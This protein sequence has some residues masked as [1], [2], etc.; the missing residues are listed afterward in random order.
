MQNRDTAILNRTKTLLQRGWTQNL[1]ARQADGS[2][3]APQHSNAVK[4]CAVGGVI[5]AAHDLGFDGCSDAL[6]LMNDLCPGG[7]VPN[8]NNSHTKVEVLSLLDR[9]IAYS[10]G[11]S[12]A[13]AAS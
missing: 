1:L 2:S 5:R 8:F 13:A 4:W 6:N 3:I 9:A 7:S 12:W 10:R 11:A